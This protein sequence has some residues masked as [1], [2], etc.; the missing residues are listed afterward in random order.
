MASY[1]FAMFMDRYGGWICQDDGAT[2]PT[3]Q[4]LATHHRRAAPLTIQAGLAGVTK[5]ERQKILDYFFSRNSVHEYNSVIKDSGG[6]VKNKERDKATS[7]VENPN[8]KSHGNPMCCTTSKRGTSKEEDDKY[9]ELGD[10]GSNAKYRNITN[11]LEKRLTLPRGS[12]SAIPNNEE[13]EYTTGD[14]PTI[15]NDNSHGIADVGDSAGDVELQGICMMEHKEGTCPICL[16][17]Y[18]TLAQSGFTG[19]R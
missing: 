11:I 13:L 16:M 10:Y 17:E 3:E 5:D 14:G 9:C 12:N 19:M 4:P 2:P 7:D 18:G 8:D 6:R 15:K 1:I